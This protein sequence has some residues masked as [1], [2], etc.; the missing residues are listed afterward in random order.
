M[1]LRARLV[2]GAAAAVAIGIVISSG[3]VYILVRNELR[4]QLDATLLTNARTIAFEP[5]GIR[6]AIHI[7]GYGNNHVYQLYVTVPQTV[8]YYQ[9]VDAAGNVYIPADYS[10]AS[11]IPLTGHALAVAA[12]QANAY[13]Y[14]AT[15]QGND[16][17]VLTL[18][19]VSSVTP[20]V[21]G[22]ERYAIQVV[23][24]LA[25]LNHELARLRLWLALGALG[26]V[27]IAAGAALLVARSA[28][29][30]VRDLSETA[31]RVRTTQD[32]SQRI[33]VEGSDELSQL[34]F[35]FNE[36]LAALDE[37]AKRQQQLVQ[38]A[39]HELRTPLTSLRTNIEVLAN[40][41]ALT[42][43]DRAQ[44]LHDV[45]EQ[46]GE[47]T[48]VV[49]EL[50]VLARGQE[51]DEATEEVRLDLLT[52]DAMRRTTRNHPGV[53]FE[54]D[55]DPTSVVGAPA[56]LERAIVNLLDNA[57]KWS[58]A[59]APIEVGLHGGEL[60]VRDH[61]PGIAEEDA[62]HVF[63]RFY[64]ATAARSMPGSGLGLA[65]VRR[66]A[67]AHGG[68]VAVEA[69]PGGGT[70]MRLRLP[71]RE[72]VPLAAAA[73]AA[74]GGGGFGGRRTR[75]GPEPGQEAERG[76]RARLLLRARPDETP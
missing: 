9:L 24:P 10:I 25:G 26:G 63:E 51:Q 1:T 58:P 37:A 30:P 19:T 22:N 6:Q 64:R 74:S 61:G 67:E 52:E 65:I 75:L 60:T 28:L 4:G 13:Y 70:L 48:D 31:E 73:P 45:I 17:R 5:Q 69:P 55:L 20:G 7:L 11:E 2:V 15:L 33:T 35:T 53:S 39:S 72:D 68:S 32:L 23:A 34:A 50:T 18:P 47:L 3:V 43:E 56:G 59:G 38:D 12:G 71:V 21:P 57:A 46:V 36:M 76:S 14:D 40:G 62:P 42:A 29:R 49:S 27:A 54:A 66:V 41:G 16:T 8:G 44:L